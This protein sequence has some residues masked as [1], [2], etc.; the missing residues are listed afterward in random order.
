M[1]LLLSGGASSLLALPVHGLS[2]PDLQTTVGRLLRAGA[3]IH[4]LNTVRREIQSAAGGGLA[5]SKN[6]DFLE[7]LR[8]IATR[9]LAA[10]RGS[11]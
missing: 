2:L 9:S 11:A 8:S 1:V 3:P 10:P 5:A 6:Q 7:H 4:D